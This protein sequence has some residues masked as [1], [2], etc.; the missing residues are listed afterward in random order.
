M[1]LKTLTIIL[2]ASGNDGEEE[3][4]GIYPYLTSLYNWPEYVALL[5]GLK[6]AIYVNW[7]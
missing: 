6:E 2:V 7:Y 5:F 1:Q 3:L 4:K